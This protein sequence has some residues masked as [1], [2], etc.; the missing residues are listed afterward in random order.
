MP[1]PRASAHW[2]S[3]VSPRDGDARET[4]VAR[5]RPPRSISWRRPRQ[6]PKSAPA[7]AVRQCP[8]ETTGSLPAPHPVSDAAHRDHI[9]R[10]GWIV[11][12]LATQMPDMNIDEVIVAHPRLR[13]YGIEKLSAAEH[14]AGPCRQRC[15]NIKLGAGQRDRLIVDEHLPTRDVDPQ[16]AEHAWRRLVRYGAA[17]GSCHGPRPAQHRA[18]P[19]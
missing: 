17:V 6:A 3:R 7:T 4:A 2:T 15:E 8:G 1:L 18:Y 5:R 16:V 19:C 11:A 9:A 12:Q 14:H 10:C 13:P